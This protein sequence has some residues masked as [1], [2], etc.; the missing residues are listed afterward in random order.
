[1]AEY[2]DLTRGAILT[3]RFVDGISYEA[4]ATKIPHINADGARKL[5]TRSKQR[6]KSNNI[7]KIL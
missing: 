4:I 5:C 2:D 6:A 1:M 7:T 3:Y